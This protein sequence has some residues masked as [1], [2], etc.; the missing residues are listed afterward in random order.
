MMGAWDDGPVEVAGTLAEGDRSASSPSSISPA[1]ARAASASGANAI[2]VAIT[3]D[4]FALFDP[5]LPM[6]GKP[7]VPHQAFNWST[8]RARQSI[9]KLSGLGPKVCWPGHYGPLEGD[10]AGKLERAAG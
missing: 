10:V 8:E 2:G 1:T 5:A 4:C 6:P 9:R 7:R 3:N